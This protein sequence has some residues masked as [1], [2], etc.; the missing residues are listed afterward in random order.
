[1]ALA[2]TAA[3]VASLE[4]QDKFSKTAAKFDATV[5]K[6]DSR[7]RSLE[8]IGENI[9]RGARNTIDNI[10]RIGVVAGGIIAANVAFGVK[11]LAELEKVEAQTQ[12]V[13]ASTKNAAGLTAGEIRD[14]AEEYENLNA[15]I[16]DKVIQSGENLLL[17]FTNINKKAF[18]PAL[19]AALDMNE[20]MG[21]GEEGLQ[22][23]I[24]RVGKA[25]QDPIN[26]A[27]ALRRVGVNL[28]DQQREQIET[29]V[30]QN[31]LYG[32]QRLILDE[33]AKEFGGSFAAAGQTATGK[34][35]KLK[36]AIEEAQMSLATAF[37]PVLEKVADKLTTFLADPK[38]QQRIEDFGETLADGF[39]D[40]VEFVS[41]LPWETIGNSLE[42][43]GKG[44]QTL[45]K[46]FTS[47]PDWVQTAVLTG[48]GLNKLTGGALGN[49]AGEL[50]KM[51]FG[52]LRGS[53]P[54][55]PVFTKEV[56]LPGGGAPGVPGGGGVGG[57]LLRGAGLA[58]ILVGAA[59]AL[60]QIEEHIDGPGFAEQKKGNDLLSQIF[61]EQ[62]KQGA[63][64]PIGQFD[65]ANRGGTIPVNVTKL[66]PGAFKATE[67]A[68]DHL[69]KDIKSNLEKG[70]VLAA[71]RDQRALMNLHRLNGTLDDRTNR[72]VIRL[73]A[74][75]QA[76][77][78]AN[79]NLDEGN[80]RQRDLA[81]GIDAARERIGTGFQ[82]TNSQL[83]SANSKLSAIQAKDFSP[84]IGVTVNASTSVSVSDVIRGV[85]HA[86]FASQVRHGF[87]EGLA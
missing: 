53:T 81:R 19:Q 47:L 48:W 27:T 49:I 20:A 75:N 72:I 8:R 17:T 4:L 76:L 24:I 21:G 44:A 63:A 85:T 29:L 60:D 13:L 10:G 74:V 33:L 54:A 58:T 52:G 65:P 50:T 66:P 45:L 18:E 25:L 7:T 1:M 79:R 59:L 11:S 6:M 38:V 30:E 71:A 73:G 69:N 68:I 64:T 82:A 86:S 37:L 40:A 55:T 23:T 51:A 12:A 14:L 3:L 41:N 16:D 28:T 36:D 87:T 42:I 15:T 70:D 35:A 46:A 83:G 31:D 26:G 80:E 34:F 77:S 39:D 43:A 57:T 78:K 5:T 9:G 61:G 84:N 62:K 56:G 67:L 32:A 22:Q 2:E